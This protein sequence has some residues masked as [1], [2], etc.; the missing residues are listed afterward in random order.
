V[1]F[2]R[3]LVNRQLPVSAHATDMTLKVVE[4][5]ELPDGWSVLGKTGM[6]YP[7]LPDYTF[8]EEHP[9]GWFVGWAT[10][11]DRTVVFA[12]LIQDDKKTE[13]TAGVRAR[14][15]LFAELPSLIAGSSK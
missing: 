12:R 9:W 14:D 15:A 3:K 2:L 8:D 11:G 13:G 5:T 7:R 4:K 6:A 10:K 1:A